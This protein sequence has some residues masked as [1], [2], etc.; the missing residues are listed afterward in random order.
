MHDSSFPLLRGSTKSIVDHPTKFLGQVV[1]V[2]YSLTKREA[3]KHLQQKV[4]IALR[5]WMRDPSEEKW[6]GDSLTLPLTLNYY[7][8]ISSTLL[9]KLLQTIRTLLNIWS[10]SSPVILPKPYGT[11]FLFLQFPPPPS[12]TQKQKWTTFALSRPHLTQPKLKLTTWSADGLNT[13]SRWTVIG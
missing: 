10:W 12:A 2:Y 11:V 8:P 4:E 1:T 13:Y 6:N 5:T 7:Q 3:S 9:E